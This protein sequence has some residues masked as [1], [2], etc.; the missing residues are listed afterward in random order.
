M[1]KVVTGATMS[2]D[3]YIADPER[4]ASTCCSSGTATATSGS[5]PPAPTVPPIRVSA[6]SAG[7]VKR[8]W[9]NAGALVVGRYLYDVTNAWG[10]RHPIDVTTVVLTHRRPDDRPEDDENFVF[11]TEGIEAA[12]AR[13]KELAGDKDV[14][15]N[16][17][18]WRGSAWRPACSTR[19]VSSW[20]PLCWA[21]G[22][23]CSPRSPA[24]RWSSRGRPRWSRARRHPPALPGEEVG[25]RWS[26]SGQPVRRCARH[27]AVRAPARRDEAPTLGYRCS[28]DVPIPVALRCR[29]PL[30]RSLARLLL[31][32]GVTSGVPPGGRVRG[33]AGFRTS[34]KGTYMP[35]VTAQDGTEIYY[36]D[37]GTGQPVVFCHGWPLNSDAW[38]AQLSS[39]RQRLPRHRPR[40][41][42][43]RPVGPAL[44]RQRHGHL[45][46]RP[47]GVIETLDLQD[48]ILVGHSTGGGEVTRYVGRHG[49]G[50][51]AKV[52]LLSAIPPLML[53]TEA[54]PK[55]CR[56][57]SSTRSGPVR[58]GSLAVLPGPQRPLLRR[59]PRGSKSRRAC[60][61]V[62]AAGRCRWA[63]RAPTTA[64]RPSPRPTSPRPQEDRRPDA[65]RPWRR[66]PDR[67]DR[68]AAGIGEDR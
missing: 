17:G 13:A 61:I 56:S 42:R 67:A 62:L 3:G 28:H 60:A 63:S 57:T 54:N 4:A 41:P 25:R 30:R 22:S 9:G 10:G 35:F 64:S 7:L 8:E 19:S 37:W 66:R 59:Q 16:G 32:R 24:R 52:V 1:T 51:V 33:S 2:L 6:A 68:A 23:R 53:K 55:G 31:V 65:D 11:V 14:I 12:V 5:R 29:P 46:R 18:R 43:P 15:V 47:G 49:T 21:P 40:P 38:D 50:R 20:C 36:K 26:P 27:S 44:G 39:G 34:A 48:V 45:R 58:G